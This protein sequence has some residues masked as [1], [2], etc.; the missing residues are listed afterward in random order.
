MIKIANYAANQQLNRFLAQIQSR[1]F[2]LEVQISSGKK[3]QSYTKI[4]ID[5]QFLVSMENS[6]DLLERFGANNQTIDFRMQVAETS[7]TSIERTIEEF[8][9]TLTNQPLTPNPSET[10]VHNLQKWAFDSMISL[11]GLLNTTSDGRYVF[12]G[13]R[14]LNQPVDLGLTTLDAFQTKYDGFNVTYPTTRESHLSDFS[15]NKNATN[16]LVNWLQFQNNSPANDRITAATNEFSHVVVGSTITIADTT[17]N[18]GNYTVLAVDPGGTWIEVGPGRLVDEGTGAAPFLNYT[19]LTGEID[20]TANI[21]P[22]LDTISGLAGTFS[23]LTA[24]M[25]FVVTG[26]TDTAANNKT[27][28]VASVSADGSTI[29][30]NEPVGGT[31]ANETGLVN[32]LTQTVP[33]TISA[34]DYYK[35]DS[36]VTEHRLDQDRSFSFDLNAINPTF[37]K[38]IRAMGI[39]AQGKFTTSGGVDNNRDRIENAKY[40]LRDALISDNAGIPP[41]GTELNGNTAAIATDLALKRLRI[42]YVSEFHSQQNVFYEERIASKENA[43]IN[44]AITSLLNETNALEAAYQTIARVSRL[45]L[46]NFMS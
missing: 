36:L 15:Q 12:G 4:S 23:T 27:Y 9:S 22:A 16:G 45:S 17:S 5:S 33:G 28:T 1:T 19:S 2:D 3:S 39:I 21:L 18:N 43:N 25:E 24:G 20:F 46:V 29:T 26:N 37:E 32:F 35:G 11:E 41:Y 30:V 10:E 14:K 44:L 38:T 8:L 40:L 42:N 6:R 31:Q 7:V 34:T 13:K